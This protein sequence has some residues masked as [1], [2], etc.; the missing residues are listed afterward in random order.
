MVASV[1]SADGIRPPFLSR[2]NGSPEHPLTATSSIANESQSQDSRKSLKRPHSP[3]GVEKSY[4]AFPFILRRLAIL[5]RTRLFNRL[6]P[7]FSFGFSLE[8]LL[9]FQCGLSILLYSGDD[10][11]P[12]V[13]GLGL[14]DPAQAAE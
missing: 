4:Y 14:Q 11:S 1:D 9:E 8:V 13:L 12:S 10:S 5:S 6:P 7:I 2:S 3:E